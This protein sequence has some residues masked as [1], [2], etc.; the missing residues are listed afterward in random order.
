MNLEKRE[1]GSHHGM[2]NF[3]RRRHPRFNVDLPMDY[4]R[5]NSAVPRDG[6]ILTSGEEGLLIY[7][8]EQMEIGQQIRMRLFFAGGPKLDKIEALAE[9]VWKDV[10]FGPASGEYRCAIKLIDISSE[11]MNKLESCLKDLLR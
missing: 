5:I 9:V 8:S 4:D 1:P 11:D 10:N 3:E 7:V 6:R 2:V